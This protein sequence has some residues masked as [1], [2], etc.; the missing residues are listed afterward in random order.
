MAISATTDA[1]RGE[2]LRAARLYG[3]KLSRSAFGDQ[4]PDLK[5]TLA[6]LEQFLVSGR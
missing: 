3:E 6:D 4:G 5:V 2:L 1:R